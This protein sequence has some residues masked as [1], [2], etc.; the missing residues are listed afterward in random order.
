[1]TWFGWILVSFS[2]VVLLVV[3]TVFVVWILGEEWMRDKRKHPPRAERVALMQRL[4]K[5]SEYDPSLPREPK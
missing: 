3:A 1:M 2:V 4:R 5:E